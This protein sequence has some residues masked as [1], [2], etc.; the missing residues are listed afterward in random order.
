[1]RKRF[2][3]PFN[4]HWK[5]RDYVARRKVQS[6][7]YNW[8]A[9]LKVFQQLLGETGLSVESGHMDY[10]NFCLSREGSI[11]T[12]CSR[13]QS[14]DDKGKSWRYPTL[15]VLCTHFGHVT[16]GQSSVRKGE[17]GRPALL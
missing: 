12:N 5:L 11:F 3:Q 8:V 9:S 17:A 13:N 16:P 1:M 7:G 14:A 6:A 4:R 10:D 2:I 15:H